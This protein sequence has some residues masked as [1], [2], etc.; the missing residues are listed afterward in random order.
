SP[1][2][3]R[4]LGMQLDV[5]SVIMP[6]VNG[7]HLRLAGAVGA[8]VACVPDV[9]MLGYQIPDEELEE[10]VPFWRNAMAFMGLPHTI[11]VNRAGKRFANEAFYRSI[12][13][14]VDAFDG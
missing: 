12:Y 11:V 7:A 1:D 8:R 10:G 3:T 14:A 5:Q 4:T 2:Y 6:Q 13:F 9:T